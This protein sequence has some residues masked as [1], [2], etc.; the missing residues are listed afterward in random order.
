MRMRGGGPWTSGTGGLHERFR[1][2]VVDD[3]RKVKRERGAETSSRAVR[4]HGAAVRLDHRFH[5]EETEPRPRSRTA[6]LGTD[7]IEAV[8]DEPQ[9]RAVHPDALILHD[10]SRESV[11]F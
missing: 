4:A 1:R 3:A 2:F 6:N 11:R 7:P 9:M 10:E 5:D 8:E